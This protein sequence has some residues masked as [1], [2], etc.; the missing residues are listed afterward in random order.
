MTAPL[1]NPFTL[2][3]TG[4]T[5][6]ARYDRLAL[7]AHFRP[8]S[9]ALGVVSGILHGPAGGV[10]ELTLVSDTVLRANPFLAIVQGTHNTVQGQYA[11]PNTAQRD[12]AIPAKDASLT[13]RALITVRVADSLE[14]GVAT[15][16]TNDG[17]WLEII[18]GPLVSSNPALPATPPNAL[19]LGEL[20]IPSSGSGSPVT[21][22]PYNPRTGARHGILPVF[23]DTSTVPG[24]GGAAGLAVGDYR[25][26]PARGLERWNGTAWVSV[27][28]GGDAIHQVAA[29]ASIALAN[30]TNLRL[31]LA[32]VQSSTP[33]VTPAGDNA[34]WT[35]NRS[36]LW[37]IGCGYRVAAIGTGGNRYAVTITNGDATVAYRQTDSVNVANQPFDIA[38]SQPVR[39]PAGQTIAAVAFTNGGAAAIY[40][41]AGAAARTFFS[42][43][44]LR[45]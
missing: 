31:P 36:G 16:A 25:D 4:V 5:T 21:M 2:G 30:G 38:L 18:P 42:A 1:G 32:S 43:V 14:A 26:H 13:R 10:G 3:A 27:T 6:A 22:T 40:T 8:S 12:L 23:D 24:H 44:F 45:P 9:A 33:D 19:N 17:A 39:F 20:T 37:L 34:S 15:S 28:V 7:G 29:G 35:L 41:A 11:V